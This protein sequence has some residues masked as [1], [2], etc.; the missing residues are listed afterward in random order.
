MCVWCDVGVC[1]GVWVGGVW[2]GGWV[3]GRAGGRAGGGWLGGRAAGGCAWVCVCVCDMHMARYSIISEQLPCD[4]IA[5]VMLRQDR[6][7]ALLQKVLLNQSP[8][9][10]N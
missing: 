8:G 9:H 5:Q 7:P 1:G 4:A 2:V 10:A 3:G 6:T